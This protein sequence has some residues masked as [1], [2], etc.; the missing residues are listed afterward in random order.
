MKTIE[1]FLETL[2][3]KPVYIEDFSCRE[4]VFNQF[5]KADETD[6]EILFAAYW[7][8]DYSGDAAVIY[9]RKSTGKYYEAYGGHCSCYGLEGQWE[10][11]EEIVAK[12]LVKRIA[13]LE[14]MYKEYMKE[15]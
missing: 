5:A 12:E 8:G 6:I 1:G 3:V 15:V 9:Y 7:P 4:D 11:D 2:R 13:E 10:R 14:A